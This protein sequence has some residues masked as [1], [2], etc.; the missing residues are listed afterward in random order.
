MQELVLRYLE[1]NY[2][3]MVEVRRHL[4][5]HPESSHQEINRPWN[6]YELR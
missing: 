6:N 3:E 4:H 5:M 1:Q 2:S